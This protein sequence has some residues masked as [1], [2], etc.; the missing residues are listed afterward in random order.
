MRRGPRIYKF[1][2]LKYLH[3]KPDRTS[4]TQHLINMA[5][6]RDTYLGCKTKSLPILASGACY[7]SSGMNPHSPSIAPEP[8]TRA[9]F[10]FLSWQ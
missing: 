4:L 2:S 9:R 3:P 1:M 8:D 6:V 10:Y 7:I 5:Y